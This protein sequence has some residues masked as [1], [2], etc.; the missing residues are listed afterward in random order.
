MAPTQPTPPKPADAVPE[1]APSTAPIV[2]SRDDVKQDR[3]VRAKKPVYYDDQRRRV[4]DVF[5]I[6]QPFA[7]K[8]KKTG[9]TITYDEFS[10]ETMEDVDPSTPDKTTTGQQVLD[11]GQ[12]AARAAKAPTGERKVID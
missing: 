1:A 5:S 2:K 4:G 12:A 8:D 9:K 11:Q 6:R 7:M 3:K 10:D